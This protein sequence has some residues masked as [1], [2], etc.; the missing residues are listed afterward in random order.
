MMNRRKKNIAPGTQSSGHPKQAKK[1]KTDHTDNKNAG[2]NA[3]KDI[4]PSTT[5]RAN[6]SVHHQPIRIQSEIERSFLIFRPSSFPNRF[7]K[8]D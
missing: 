6:A 2:Q 3:N 4:E 1:Q 7:P 5:I 8:K